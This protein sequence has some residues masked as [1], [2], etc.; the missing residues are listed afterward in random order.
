LEDISLQARQNKWLQH[1]ALIY[2]GTWITASELSDFWTSVCPATPP[3]K[4]QRVWLIRWVCNRLDN[5]GF[6][7]WQGSQ[8]YPFS[9]MSRQALDPT[10]PPNQW[11]PAALSCG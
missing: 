5:L 3:Y 10:L 2:D 4:S 7:Y 9:K 6:K 11:V 1:A 8:L